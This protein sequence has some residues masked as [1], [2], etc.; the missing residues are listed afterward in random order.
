MKSCKSSLQSPFA[1]HI[2]AFISQKRA[3]GYHYKA[4]EY[5]LLRFDAFARS[6]T[7]LSQR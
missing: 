3:I 5:Q 2:E 4:E 6:R 7:L 1:A